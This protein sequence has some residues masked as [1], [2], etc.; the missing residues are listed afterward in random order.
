MFQTFRKGRIS[1]LIWV[2]VQPSEKIHHR[3]LREQHSEKATHVFWA[4]IWFSPIPL[5]AA[6]LA[7]RA[8]VT[9]VM[10]FRGR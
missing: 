9:S 4:G 1:S 3:E 7:W 10:N 6:L 2:T 5:R 8:S